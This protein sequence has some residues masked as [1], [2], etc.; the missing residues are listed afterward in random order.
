MLTSPGPSGERPMM[1]QGILCG[2]WPVM[3]VS[4]RTM[5]IPL[6][7]EMLSLYLIRHRSEEL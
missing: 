5:V 3:C 1:K 4:P 2:V 7:R 6:S